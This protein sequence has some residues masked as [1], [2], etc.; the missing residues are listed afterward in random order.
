[1]WCTLRLSE[2]GSL[3]ILSNATLPLLFVE[4]VLPNFGNQTEPML[5]VILCMCATMDEDRGAKEQIFLI[6][7]VHCSMK[8]ESHA[9]CVDTA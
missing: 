6:M 8:G 5:T 7:P 2:S 4:P 3:A 1:M 9:A